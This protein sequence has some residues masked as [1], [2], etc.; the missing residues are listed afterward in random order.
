MAGDRREEVVGK[1]TSIA[2]RTLQAKDDED[3]TLKNKAES[4]RSAS[5]ARSRA[6]S[7]CI[8]QR[9][10][11]QLQGEVPSQ[12]LIDAFVAGTGR[13]HGAREVESLLD[14]PGTEAA[15]HP[16][17][18]ATL[19]R[20]DRE[21]CPDG[22]RPAVEDVWTVA[23]DAAEPVALADEARRRM[24]R[25]GARRAGSGRAHVRHQHRLRP[26][27]RR[28]IPEELT[29]ELQL[30][31]LR[32]HACGVG[33]PYPDE[34][35]RAAMLLRANALAKGC[36]GARVETVELLA[37]VPEPR[38]RCRACRRAARS[39]P[40]AISRRSR[41]WR[42][43]SSARARR[44]STASCSPARRRSP[45]VGPR[46]GAARGEGGALARQRHAVHG[47]DGGARARPRA[48]ARD[49]GRPR[50]RA[51]ARG[52]AG[53]AH[54]LPP[55]DPRAARPLRGQLDS[56]AN[57]SGCSKARRSSRRTAGA[58]RCRTR[59]RCAAR[60]RCTAPAATCSTTSSDTVAVELNAA[61][62]NPLVLVEERAARLERELPRAAARVRA[63]RARDGGRRARE[64][65]RAPRRAARQPEP[66]RRAAAV[67]HAR[68]A[69]STPGS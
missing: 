15:V 33:E 1:F 45:R 27:R 62:D 66:L 49:G 18:G 17:A 20:R 25:A 23:V 24:R 22:R 8:A 39:G 48:P 63:R 3:A 55:G 30:R 51:V 31:L 2:T 19:A 34:I 65:L 4:E 11:A 58:T 59:T 68:R 69:G 14:T 37:R 52:A 41:T 29:E 44:G 21:P 9:G 42:C 53:L 12:D 35:V 47:R 7:A 16:L 10:V 61:T 13:A 46:A 67:P 50:L 56:A 5:S 57:V 43:R 36:S 60:R 26:V 32:S 6:R 28:S 54:E 38:R 64:H 40:A